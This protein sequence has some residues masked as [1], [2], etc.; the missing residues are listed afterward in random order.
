[1]QQPLALPGLLKVYGKYTL[2]FFSGFIFDPL[3]QLK[4]SENSFWLE[5]G[6]CNETLS[7]L[8][9]SIKK[10]LKEDVMNIYIFFLNV[11]IHLSHYI[12]ARCI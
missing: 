12:R 11:S 8:F 9:Q 7:S 6:P 5:K 3:E 2:H 1:M 4:S 10:S